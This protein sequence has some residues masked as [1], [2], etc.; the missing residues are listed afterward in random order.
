LQLIK[1]A[2]Q[3]KML[4]KSLPSKGVPNIGKNDNLNSFLLELPALV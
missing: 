3:I 2:A 1:A 4:R